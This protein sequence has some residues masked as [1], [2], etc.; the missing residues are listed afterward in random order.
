MEGKLHDHYN[1]LDTAQSQP[2]LGRLQLGSTDSANHLSAFNPAGQLA[3]PGM[4]HKQLRV[5][6]YYFDESDEALGG[7]HQQDQQGLM[8]GQQQ[9]EQEQKSDGSSEHAEQQQRAAGKNY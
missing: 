7:E 4:Q 8:E 5:E 3:R 9:Q 1:G 2:L 6:D